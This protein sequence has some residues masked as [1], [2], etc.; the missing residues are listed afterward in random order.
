MGRRIKTPIKIIPPNERFKG[1]CWSCGVKKHLMFID[2]SVDGYLCGAC[3]PDAIIV[4][5]ALTSTDGIRNPQPGEICEA[6]NH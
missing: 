2:H 1:E 6:D 5:I 3:A 4:E